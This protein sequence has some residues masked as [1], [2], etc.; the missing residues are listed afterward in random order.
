[1]G[2]VALLATVV[3][4]GK[5][6]SAETL[7]AT[8]KGLTGWSVGYETGKPQSEED[9]FVGST[10]TYSWIIGS[11]SATI[12]TQSSKAA[13]SV[14]ATDTARVIS[15]PSLVTFIV[16]YERGTWIHTYFP[17][18]KVI[19]VSRHVDGRG[20]FKDSAAGGLFHGR[21]DASVR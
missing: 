19:M 11:P 7:T 17:A 3:A 15:K 8:C 9:G 20:P 1:M 14:P 10:F 13:G 4:L 12:I 5:C 18:A 21:C 2:K 16:S 6:C